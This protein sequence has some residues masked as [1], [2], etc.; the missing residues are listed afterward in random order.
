VTPEV[1]ISALNEQGDLTTNYTRG[2]FLKLQAGDVLRTLPTTD[3]S[4]EQQGN[5]NLLEVNVTVDPASLSGVPS[6]PGEMSYQFS[7]GD[8]ILYP[9]SAVSLVSPFNPSLSFAINEVKDSDDVSADS[10]PL[11]FVPGANLEIRYGRWTMENVY[12]PED[13]SS[14]EMPFQADYWTGDRFELNAADNCSVWNSVDISGTSNHHTLTM[15]SGTLAGGSGGPLLL[16]PNGS[17]GTDTLIWQQPVWLQHFWNNSP[18]L[19]DPSALATFGVY[20]GHDRV[21][22]WREVLN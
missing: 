5:T 12:G 6:N 19:Q 10:M 13:V 15:D 4:Q 8:T 1:F 22:Y 9:K 14:L 3:S 21:I 18:T 2:D 20:R 17:Q 7:T 11:T 16:E